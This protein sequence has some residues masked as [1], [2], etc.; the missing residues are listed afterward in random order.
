MKQNLVSASL[1]LAFASQA[2]AALETV[3]AP[4]LHL[5]VYYD[6]SNE[7]CNDV[8]GNGWAEGINNNPTFCDGQQDR[9][10][11]DIGTDQIVAVNASLVMANPEEYCGR[12]VA[13][14]KS[15]GTQFTLGNN[16]PFVIW[17]SCAAC[18]DNAILDV[19]AAAFVGLKG[20]T[21]EGDNPA[22]SRYEILDT[23]YWEPVLPD[24]SGGGPAPAGY[25][26]SSSAGIPS[27]TSSSHT[28]TPT[29][30][31]PTAQVISSALAEIAIPTSSSSPSGASGDCG[32]GAWQCSGLTLQICNHVAGSQTGW[33]F[34]ENCPKTCKVA[35][36]SVDCE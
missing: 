31:A 11:N 13:I 33:E 24:G 32:F 4:G 22:I 6:V 21:C 12:E 27:S 30:P 29:P 9:T 25:N 23:Y 15:D 1:V 14:Y 26:P 7:H 18:V 19:S 8:F 20:G 10:L 35:S 2:L 5:T 34:V 28:T 36:G 16:K 3:A 17:D